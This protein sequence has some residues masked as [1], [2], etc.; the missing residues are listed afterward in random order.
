MAIYLRKCD[1]ALVGNNLVEV[2]KR[3]YPELINK[4]KFWNRRLKTDI[5]YANKLSHHFSDRANLTSYQKYL[6]CCTNFCEPEIVIEFT[7]II[8]KTNVDQEAFTK[9]C[10]EK[11]MTVLELLKKEDIVNNIIDYPSTDIITTRF[12]SKAVRCTAKFKSAP[13]EQVDLS[14]L[15]DIIGDIIEKLFCSGKSG[16]KSTSYRVMFP[17]YKFVTPYNLF[18]DNYLEYTITTDEKS[19]MENPS[20]FSANR[21]ASMMVNMIKSF[22]SYLSV[23]EKGKSSTRIRLYLEDDKDK[24][25][26]IDK[27]KSLYSL[28]NEK[29]DLEIHV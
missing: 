18:D 1:S 20:Q 6:Y 17:D 27:I 29:G 12:Q 14:N 3:L 23:S 11:A 2:I 9:S 16:L 8:G 15:K 5:S 26:I 24:L 28:F 13:M 19:W 7:S 22:D 21:L 10:I 4:E 25:V